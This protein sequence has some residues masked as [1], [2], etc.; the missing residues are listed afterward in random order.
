MDWKVSCWHSLFYCEIWSRFLIFALISRKIIL[1]CKIKQ[2]KIKQKE[3]LFTYQW[4]V[5]LQLENNPPM[6]SQSNPSYG[7][8]RTLLDSF[9]L[10]S[11]NLPIQTICHAL[12]NTG[13]PS[14]LKFLHY[15]ETFYHL[16]C[17][18]E[19]YS[20]FN[21][22]ASFSFETCRS[23]YGLFKKKSENMQIGIAFRYDTGGG[24]VA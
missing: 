2:Y 12:T 24:S 16:Y 17:W 23:I 7:F 20:D 6:P 13:L 8:V 22:Y 19:S 9:P 3:D 14:G 15:L 1:G 4:I 5:W 18:K 11:P 10:N 21:V